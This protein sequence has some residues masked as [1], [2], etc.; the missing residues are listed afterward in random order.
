MRP[1]KSSLS[2]HC[3]HGE[4][5]KRED[6]F[7]SVRPFILC[8]SQTIF[9]AFWATASPLFLLLEPDGRGRGNMPFIQ[10]IERKEE[11]GAGTDGG[12]EGKRR[13]RRSRL[14]ILRPSR[15]RA[16]VVSSSR[17]VLSLSS[18]LF[19]PLKLTKD[20]QSSSTVAAKLVY[21][22]IYRAY[23]VLALYL[24]SFPSLSPP[25]PPKYGK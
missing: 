24:S 18:L 10:G 15:Q 7:A 8:C 11:E 22:R 12:G 4:I 9:A 3:M 20:L 5:E 23:T 6:G 1:G 17:A 19:S 14:L 13:Q 2:D 21:L 25:P 16:K